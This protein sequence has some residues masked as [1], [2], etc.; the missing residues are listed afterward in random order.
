[1]PTKRATEHSSSSTAAAIGNEITTTAGVFPCCLFFFILLV[2]VLR[3]HIDFWHDITITIIR[4]I[5][6]IF[7]RKNPRKYRNIWSC[8]HSMNTEKR[9]K[10]YV[11][12]FVSS[13]AAR[14]QETKNMNK[15]KRCRVSTRKKRLHIKP[16]IIFFL[17]VFPTILLRFINLTVSK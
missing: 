3:Q 17:S 12:A 9:H 11:F 6:H 2:L 4:S 16:N 10:Y 13:L 14:I 5:Y 15:T 7:A 8:V 1:M